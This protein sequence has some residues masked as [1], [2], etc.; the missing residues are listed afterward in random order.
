MNDAGLVVGHVGP[1]AAQWTNSAGSWQ[2]ADI[3]GIVSGAGWTLN[4]VRAVDDAGDLAGAGVHNGA[5]Q[6]AYLLLP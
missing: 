4:D 6:H 2:Y 1:Q 5:T 3:S